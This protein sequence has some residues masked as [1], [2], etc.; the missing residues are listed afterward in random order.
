L[1][2]GLQISVDPGD[3]DDNR[4]GPVVCIVRLGGGQGG[5]RFQDDPGVQFPGLDGN[6]IYGNVRGR[7]LNVSGQDDREAET[8]EKQPKCFPFHV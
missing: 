7:G 3:L 5:I 2:L 8:G 6:F 1:D 4:L